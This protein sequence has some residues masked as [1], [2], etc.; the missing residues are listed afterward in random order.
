MPQ[1]A[2]EIVVERPV[3][4]ERIIDRFGPSISW[5]S[6]EASLPHGL[7]RILRQRAFEMDLEE[8][9]EEE[10][11]EEEGEILA[12]ELIFN[13]YVAEGPRA[14]HPLDPSW[15][16]LRRLNFLGARGQGLGIP[17]T[18][19][20]VPWCESTTYFGGC[21]GG[22][23]CAYCCE[24]V[25]VF[26]CHRSCRNVEVEQLVR[27]FPQVQFLDKV[28]VARCCTMTGAY[29]LTEQKTVE[30]P[31]LQCS[32]KRGTMSLL[33]MS[34]VR[35]EGASDS[36]SSPEFVDL[37]VCNEMMGFQRGFGGDAGVGFFRVLR[38]RGLLH[39]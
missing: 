39:S 34:S 26:Q 24:Q 35:F 28:D 32:D 38:R 21:G 17:L 15:V 19:S 14:W 13:G 20:W 4:R 3:T 5:D 36:V 37:P 2:E 31:Q 1:I 16:P 7:F 9:E 30:F 8:E 6:L 18:P 11:D 25:V 22:P 23:A 27:Y 33:C 29:G 10:E 12:S